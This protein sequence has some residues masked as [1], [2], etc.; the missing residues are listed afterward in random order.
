MWDVLYAIDTSSSMGEPVRGWNS[1]SKIAAVALAIT[2]AIK[3]GAFPIGSRVGVITFSAATRAMG[4][5]LSSGQE[6]TR[7]LVPLTDSKNL[8]EKP[9]VLGAQL[10]SIRVGGATPSGTAIEKGV[11]ILQKGEG[12]AKRIKKLILVTDERSNV[13]P[14]PEKVVDENLARLVILDIVGIGGRMNQEVLG[15]A[16]MRT[17]GRF[18]EVSTEAELKEAMRP[19][20]EIRGLKGDAT[21]IDGAK[22]MAEALASQRNPNTLEFKQ[23]LERARETRAKLNKRL[24]EIL[25]LKTS[26]NAQV[27]ELA[28]KLADGKGITM[29]EYAEKVWP[30]ASELPQLEMIEAELRKTMEALA[31]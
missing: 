10:G 16:T 18:I 14:R 30:S 12:A 8:A 3:G 22:K 4:L 11:E 25:M 15:Q 20:I 6:M 31:V 19:A 1:P 9:E 7:L 28:A 26:A 24:V 5:M 13:G 2:D 27:K 29:K 23:L 17:G 21:L